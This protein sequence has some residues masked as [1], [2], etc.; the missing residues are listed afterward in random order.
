MNTNTS[1][2]RTAPEAV[3]C[4]TVDVPGLRQPAKSLILDSPT[5][6]IESAHFH[7][8]PPR[9]Q[10]GNVIGPG[11]ILALL[12]PNRRAVGVRLMGH[13]DIHRDLPMSRSF[14]ADQSDRP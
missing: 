6:P 11:N 4:R 2:A 12:I 3:P 1:R 10:A 5:A 13:H 7:S 9:R 8:V 14:V